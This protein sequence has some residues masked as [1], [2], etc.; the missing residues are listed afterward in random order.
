MS[1][2]DSLFRTSEALRM[3]NNVDVDP[4][5]LHVPEGASHLFV[6]YDSAG[7]AW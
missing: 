7:S 5:V 6:S 3:E 1:P 4:A 2:S